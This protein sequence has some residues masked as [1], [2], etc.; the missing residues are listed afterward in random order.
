MR[1][2][3]ADFRPADEVFAERRARMTP[4]ERAAYDEAVAAAGRQMDAAQLAY[5]LDLLRRAVANVGVTGMEEA[6]ASLSDDRAR[7]DLMV[8]T[9]R[10]WR[11]RV[12][13][14]G[15]RTITDA[16]ERIDDA[17]ADTLPLPPEED[18][19]TRPRVAPTAAE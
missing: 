6:R 8:T 9:S 5:D 18:W 2:K 12:P 14:E 16:I 11:Y 19:V 3:E 13:V 1:Y 15:G 17:P 4:A 7:V 10:G